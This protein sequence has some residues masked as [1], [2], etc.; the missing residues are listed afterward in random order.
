M[1]IKLYLLCFDWLTGVSGLIMS[2]AILAYG[3]EELEHG[4]PEA[5]VYEMRS[6]TL[7]EPD[8][9]EAFLDVSS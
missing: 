3:R 7:V 8:M 1:I 6:E 2:V 4:K 9:Q 5:E